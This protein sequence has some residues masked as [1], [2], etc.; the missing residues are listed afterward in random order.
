M[1]PDSMNQKKLRWLIWQQNGMIIRPLKRIKKQITIIQCVSQLSVG[2]S[3]VLD[4][5]GRGG[6]T[7]LS[8]NRL[9]T[10]GVLDE[11]PSHNV[12]DVMAV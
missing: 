11:V 9:D 2:D 6:V 7:E 8:L 5:V 1:P 3:G 4:G 12:A 10:A